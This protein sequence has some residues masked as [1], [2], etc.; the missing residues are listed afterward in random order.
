MAE[1]ICSG[2][3]KLVLCFAFYL[4]WWV[5]AFNPTRPVRGMR[6]GW[7]LVPAF[8]LGLWGLVDIV[9]G[10]VFVGGPLPSLGIVAAGVLVYLAL[11][12]ITGLAMHRQVTSE[13]LIIVLWATVAALEIN[14]LIT[15]GVFGARVGLVLAGLSL[16]AAA[17]SLVCYLRFYQLEAAP[18]FVDGAIPLLLAGV[19][20][21]VIALCAGGFLGSN[22]RLSNEAFGIETYVSTYDA[23]GDGVD[24]QSDILASARAYVATRPE[25]DDGYF[26][27][28][29]PPE[30]RGACTDVVAYALL[31]AGY[32]L[33]ALVDEDVRGDPAAYGIE[34]ADSNID[35]RRVA[36]LIVFLDRHATPLTC[37]TTEIGQ[38]QGGDIVAYG[39]HIGIVSDVRNEQ[40]VP[41]LIHHGRPGQ[42]YYEENCLATYGPIVGHWR[43]SA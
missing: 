25:Y 20:T 39:N 1:L 7:L 18:A 17:V 34:K 11:L 22:A 16:L 14:T 10:L 28:G 31:G 32:D 26:E 40:G 35:Y 37:D 29:W 33:Q 24:D 5:V 38:W 6:S 43:W 27:G 2:N 15:L 19:M 8:G 13:L 30:G 41:W 36:N 12:A 21:G 42:R 9:R 23:D 4:A 3:I